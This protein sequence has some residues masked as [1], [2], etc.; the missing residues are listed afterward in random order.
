MVYGGKKRVSTSEIVYY[1]N[2]MLFIQRIPSIVNSKSVTLVKTNIN[3][4]FEGFV[5]QWYTFQLSNFDCNIFN[6]NSG[7]KN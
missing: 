1:K 5:P 4:F 3:I 2:V 7:I 6:N